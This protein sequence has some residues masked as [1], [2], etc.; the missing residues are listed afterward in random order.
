[1]SAFNVNGGATV[2]ASCGIVD[3]SNSSSAMNSSGGSSTVTATSIAVAGNVTGCCY[4]PTPQT[5]VPPEPDPVAQRAAPTL[6]SGCDYT[7]FQVSIGSPETLTPGVHCNG[8][9]VNAGSAVSF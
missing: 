3:D 6:S 7:S 2:A 8:I 4:F 9:T 1:A 5:G